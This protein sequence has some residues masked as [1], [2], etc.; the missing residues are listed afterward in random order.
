MNKQDNKHL[1]LIV[2]CMNEQEVL[3]KTNSELLTLLNKLINKNLTS[4]SLK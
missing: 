1:A 3:Q 2:P 4:S